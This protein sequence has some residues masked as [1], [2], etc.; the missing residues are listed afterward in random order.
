MSGKL[1][2]V[3]VALEAHQFNRAI[4]L[5]LALPKDNIL[6]Q[7]LLA[8][9]YNKTSQRHK[10]LL[11]LQSILGEEGFQELQLECKYA[12]EAWEEQNAAAN[13]ASAPPPVP[14]PIAP[15]KK[16]KKGKKKPAPA[17]SA[18]KASGPS[19]DAAHSWSLVDHLDN[20]P[21]IDENW[22]N[23]PPSDQAITDEVCFV[24]FCSAVAVLLL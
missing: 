13:A 21:D 15:T 10:A 17:A 24:H 16:G 14:Q 19:L 7:A 2:A 18:P 4:K 8:H 3:Y 12:K 1:H 23:L 11:V 9:A 22:E 5:C 20:P 6:G